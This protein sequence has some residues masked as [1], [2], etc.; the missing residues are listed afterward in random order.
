[1]NFEVVATEYFVNQLEAFPEK[2]KKIIKSKIE[3]VKFDPFRYK[4][5]HS[6]QFSQVYRIRLNIENEESRL[7]YTVLGNKI[8]FVCVLDRKNDYKDLEK[9]LEKI[10]K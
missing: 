1:M 6:K 9:Y 5:I 4:K 2:V 8:I 7:I 10:N 3:F